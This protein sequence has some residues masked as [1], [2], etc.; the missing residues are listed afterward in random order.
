M[1]YESLVFAVYIFHF[2]AFLNQ[3]YFPDFATM[4]TTKQWVKAIIIAAGIP[5]G[6]SSA[7]VESD[8]GIAEQLLQSIDLKDPAGADVFG[9]ISGN[10]TAHRKRRGFVS[11]LPLPRFATDLDDALRWVKCLSQSRLRPLR[12][13]VTLAGMALVEQVLKSI[14]ASKQTSDRDTKHLIVICGK[15]CA[16]LALVRCRDTCS[17]IRQIVAEYVFRW[18]MVN[19]EVF[20]SS[21]FG[22]SGTLQNALTNLLVDDETEVRY[23][24][25]AGLREVITKHMHY[26]FK[27]NLEFNQVVVQSFLSRCEDVRDYPADFESEVHEHALLIEAL[28]TNNTGLIDV[29]E[30]AGLSLFDSVYQVLWD[31]QVPVAI[32][33]TIARIVSTNVLGT[34]ILNPQFVHHSR[35]VEM[36]IAFAKQ[37]DPWNSV[38]NQVPVFESF[39]SQFDP[40]TLSSYL[41]ACTSVVSVIEILQVVQLIEAIAI[42]ADRNSYVLK[43][44][45]M[46]S[47]I[48]K[49]PSES[50]HAINALRLLAISV[51]SDSL[52][53]D[54]LLLGFLRKA[55]ASTVYTHMYLGYRAWA[56]LAERR[57]KIS[58]ELVAWG[59]QLDAH[60]TF[61][62]LTSIH[63]LESAVHRPL[64]DLAAMNKL[65]DF[66]D[67]GHIPSM[68]LLVSAID[69]VFIQ[70]LKPGL[71]L[72]TLELVNGL[73]HKLVRLLERLS[74]ETKKDKTAEAQLIRSFSKYRLNLL[75]LD[76]PQPPRGKDKSTVELVPSVRW[77]G[78]SANDYVVSS[79]IEKERIDETFVQAME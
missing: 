21:I 16:V 39:V 42:V 38:D 57:P 18:A 44:D 52:P 67:Q 49:L 8:V 61:G 2:F 35:G 59:S 47:L 24:A 3:A 60:L 30:K 31:Q 68:T 4:S 36:L 66:I 5:D 11:S 17:V 1:I 13:A 76:D 12:S 58:Q 22:K 32:R 27:L 69:I 50:L 28:L 54:E 45:C 63:A 78:M 41:A 9:L 48:E 20:T 25:I 51:D 43:I 56:A 73:K 70:I 74:A 64:P 77:Y 46:Q 29:F 72:R 40:A 71:D 33:S 26:K 23:A 19:P 65:V 53:R 75:Y 34:D 62:T 7:M 37:Y 15:L 55:V 6:V 14:Q 10:I 79:L